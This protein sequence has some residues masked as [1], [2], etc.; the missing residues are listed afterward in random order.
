MPKSLPP[1]VVAACYREACR[2]DVLAAKPGNVSLDSPGHGMEA[3]DFL[4]S[5]RVSAAPLCAGVCGVGAAVR[6]AI[7]ATWSAVGCNTNLG[8]VLLAAPLAQAALRPL[9]GDLRARLAQVLANLDVDDAIGVYAAIRE[10]RPAGLGR[11]ATGDVAVAP[12]CDLRR[13][14]AL[15]AERDRIAWNYVHDYADVFEC[16]LPRLCAALAN[17]GGLA[18]AVLASYLA[19]LAHTPDTHVARKY[20][21]GRARA[22]RRR[23]GEVETAY[24]ACED[25]MARGSLVQAFDHELKREGVNPGTTADLTVTSLFAMYLAAALQDAR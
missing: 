2:F 8:I 25:A 1:A 7:A 23:A 12:S 19:L 17:A 9:P 18:D 21:E 16:G 4:L 20:G 22:V 14:M 11:V 10:A 13:A 6:E 24:K 5:A 15:A 3:R